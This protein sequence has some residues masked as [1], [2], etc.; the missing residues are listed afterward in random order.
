MYRTGTFI[1]M[2]ASNQ[3]LE[4]LLTEPVLIF[5]KY[6]IFSIIT[7]KILTPKLPSII[8]GV[9]VRF[10]NTFS[11]KTAK[12]KIYTNFLI[13]KLGVRVIHVCAL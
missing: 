7:R 13:K 2:I 4:W 9:I 12:K 3:Y 6:R 11:R 10:N 5:I 8:R 1:I